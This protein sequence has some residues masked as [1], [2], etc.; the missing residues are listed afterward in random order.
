MDFVAVFAVCPHKGVLN[1]KQH[2]WHR[3][4]RQRVCISV[5]LVKLQG[6]GDILKSLIC[7]EL[8]GIGLSLFFKAQCLLQIEGGLLPHRDAIFCAVCTQSNT[9][10]LMLHVSMQ[11]NWRRS[12]FFEQCCFEL[13]LR[14]Q[15]QWKMG[16]I[17]EMA[18]NLQ[19]VTLILKLSLKNVLF[20]RLMRKA[21]LLTSLYRCFYQLEARVFKNLFFKGRV[22]F[23]RTKGRH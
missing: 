7:S 1:Y 22:Y 12:R 11:L 13:Y 5:S 10:L 3:A 18:F 19:L 16:W 21:S 2:T 8:C 15:W 23:S 14:D 9:L 17:G 20:S 4:I 6:G